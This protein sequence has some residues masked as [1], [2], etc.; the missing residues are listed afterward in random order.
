MTIEQFKQQRF[1][2]GD[3]ARYIDGNLYEVRSVNFDEMLIGL[4]M[5]ISGDEPDAISWV[6]CENIEI[7]GT[8]IR[9]IKD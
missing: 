6:R 3:V 4:L 7:T 5:N 2:R 1:G 8:T 9:T